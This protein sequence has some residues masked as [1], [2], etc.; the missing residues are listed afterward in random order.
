MPVVPV[1]PVFKL[2]FEKKK[3]IWIEQDR[4]LFVKGGF[5]FLSTGTCLGIA[6]N[7]A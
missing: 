7:I 5:L 4:Q 6:F 2:I 3:Q 1:L